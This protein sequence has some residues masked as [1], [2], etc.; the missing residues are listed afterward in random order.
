MLSGMFEPNMFGIHFILIFFL[1]LLYLPESKVLKGEVS[2]KSLGFID[3]LNLFFLY[4]YFIQE[5][6]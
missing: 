5:K 4:I 3:K 2:P 1:L 6:G